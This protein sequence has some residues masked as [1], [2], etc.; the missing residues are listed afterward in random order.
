MLGIVVP[1]TVARAVLEGEVAGFKGS[2]WGSVVSLGILV[3]FV[4]G[5]VVAGRSAAAEPLTHGGL[6]G[7]AAV[8]VWIPVRVLIWALRGERRRLF[9]GAR[10]PL[11]PGQIFGALL[12]AT[13]FGMVGAW[14]G[15]RR[16]GRATE[17]AG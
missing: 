16:A 6:A 11:A 12:L 8:A 15:A 4:L 2:G 7:V 13:A 1:I 9:S 10:A 14:W 5:G 17:P 3:G